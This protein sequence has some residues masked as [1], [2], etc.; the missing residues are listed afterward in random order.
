[1]IQKLVLLTTQLIA[2]KA[3]LNLW[4]HAYYIGINIR[5]DSIST[6]FYLNNTDVSQVTIFLTAKLF[7]EHSVNGFTISVKKNKRN[8]DLWLNNESEYRPIDRP[9]NIPIRIPDD[10]PNVRS[11]SDKKTTPKSIPKERLS[12]IPSLV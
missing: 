7:N 9:I 6:L 1:M 3:A 8:Y 12:P 4:M 10:I 2:R 11:I 5:Q